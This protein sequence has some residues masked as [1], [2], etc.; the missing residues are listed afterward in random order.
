ML[1]Q[2]F[3]FLHL[4]ILSLWTAS[5]ATCRLRHQPNKHDI[6]ITGVNRSFLTNTKNSA[7]LETTKTVHF[8]SR[9]HLHAQ[10][11]P[12]ALDPV[13]QE[14]SQDCLYTGCNTGTKTHPGWLVSGARES[15]RSSRRLSAPSA[16]PPPPPSCSPP[17]PPRRPLWLSWPVATASWPCG[18][19]SNETSAG[20][21][22]S[23]FQDVKRNRVMLKHD[24]VKIIIVIII[25]TTSVSNN[26]KNSK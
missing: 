10:G 1:K 12:Y 23:T 21:S 2:L 5:S 8:A 17:L 4:R 26:N 22:T 11:P 24:S 16:P 14:L 25:K 18:C 7:K 3:Q 9:W 20:R 15:A 6:K 19:R 13:P